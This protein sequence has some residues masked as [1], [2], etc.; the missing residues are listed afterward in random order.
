MQP[1]HYKKTK[2]KIY[3]YYACSLC[4]PVLLLSHAGPYYQKSEGS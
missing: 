4:I 1:S 3:D 2:N